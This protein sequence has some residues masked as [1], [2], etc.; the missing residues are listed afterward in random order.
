M[1]SRTGW[2][3]WC[4]VLL[5]EVALPRLHPTPT[6]GDWALVSADPIRRGRSNPAVFHQVR[7]CYLG[8]DC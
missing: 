1:A 6:A 2:V 5:L 3:R 4:F 7:G 8:S